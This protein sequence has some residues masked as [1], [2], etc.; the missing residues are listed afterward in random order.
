[1]QAIERIRLRGPVEKGAQNTMHH[2]VGIAPDRRR[3]MRVTHRCQREV[4]LVLGGITGLLELPQH[5]VTQD[6]LL[7]LSLDLS[8]QLLIIAWRDR[9]AAGGH[10]HFL[11]NLSSIAGPLDYRKTLHRQ[12][13]D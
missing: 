5:Q 1:M 3:K 11:S 12:R 2:Q 4:S 8:D 7:R 9:N 10:Y 13:S 6:S